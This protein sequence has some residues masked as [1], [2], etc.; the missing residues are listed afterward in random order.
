VPSA[1]CHGGLSLSPYPAQVTLW[2]REAVPGSAVF[3][4]VVCKL[5]CNAVSTGAFIAKGCVFSNRMVALNIS[6][7]KLLH[8]ATDIVHQLAGVAPG[9]ARMALLAAI[10]HNAQGA[11]EAVGA[12]PQ[13]FPFCQPPV[14][15]C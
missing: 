7:V 13:V 4:A 15:V 12:L 5:V 9:A 2:T 14:W 8:R 1:G 6:N 3:G 11:L 10:Y